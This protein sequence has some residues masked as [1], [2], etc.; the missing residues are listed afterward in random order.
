MQ[1]HKFTKLFILFAVCLILQ[2]RSVG[3]QPAKPTVKLKVDTN[4]FE[5]TGGSKTYLESF[6]LHS[7]V[8]GRSY[9]IAHLTHSL[10]GIP[11]PLVDPSGQY[12]VFAL[13]NMCGFEGEGMVIWISDIYGKKRTPI[14]GRCIY[15]RPAGFITANGNTYLHITGESETPEK[16]FWLYDLKKGEFVLHADGEIKA[17]G[18]GQFA[19]GQENEEGEFKPI[20]KVTV[21]TLINRAAPLKLLPRYPTEG[22]T[23]NNATPVYESVNC[24]SEGDKLA[25]KIPA[26]NT[27]VIILTQCEDGGY[28]IYGAGFKGKV[29]KGAIKPID[30][31]VKE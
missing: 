31:G 15:L 5:V 27:R 30:F 14:L 22:V 10:V 7:V 16:E 20:G 23:L 9:F 24:D 21:S 3:A 12:V 18:K 2:A 8:N 29:K 11:E 4:K 6:T 13:N 28:E 19:Y 25:M 1:I 26:A 17:Q